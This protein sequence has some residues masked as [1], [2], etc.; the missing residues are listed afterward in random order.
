MARHALVVEPHV[1][2][3]LTLQQ[4]IQDV[5]LVDGC[6]SFAAGRTRLLRDHPDVLVAN[7]RL[8]SYNGLHLVYLATPTTRSIVY[9]DREDHFLLREAQQAGAFVESPERLPSSVASYVRATLPARDRRDCTMCDRR[10]TPRGGRRA[11]DAI[12]TR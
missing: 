1:A 2:R 9:M 7:L 11:A 12:A 6:S 5:A 10:Q 8:G 3:L 4:S